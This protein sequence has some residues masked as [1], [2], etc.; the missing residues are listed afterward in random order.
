MG[1]SPL[2]PL[3]IFSQKNNINEK[4]KKKKYPQKW[5]ESNK[6][7]FGENEKKKKGSPEKIVEACKKGKIIN[8]EK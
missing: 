6:N 5:S 7:K 2:G 3:I 8:L 4:R 1:N